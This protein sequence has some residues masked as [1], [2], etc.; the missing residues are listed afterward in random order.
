MFQIVVYSIQQ[1][2]TPTILYVTSFLDFF[3]AILDLGFFVIMLLNFLR[4]FLYRWESSR[5]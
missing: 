1:K 2:S 3:R 5:S 4:A